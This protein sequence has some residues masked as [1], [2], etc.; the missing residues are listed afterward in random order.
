[1]DALGVT[2][3]E[4]FRHAIK[5][6]VE[7]NNELREHNAIGKDLR[8]R[9]KALKNVVIRFMESAMLDV[10]SVNHDGKNGELVIKTSKRSKTLTKDA[11]VRQIQEYLSQ[12]TDVDQASERAELIWDHMQSARVVTES[13]NLSMRKF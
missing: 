2:E 8:A 4:Q 7:T 13:R 3:Q 9:L 11:A 10:C 12:E 1:M 5:T 6:L